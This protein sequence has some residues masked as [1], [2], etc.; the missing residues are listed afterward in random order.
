MLVAVL[1]LLAASCGASPHVRS[2]AQVER[3]L[4]AAGLQ[5]HRAT[6]TMELESVDGTTP[7]TPPIQEIVA[8]PASES[9][10]PPVFTVDHGRAVVY[11]YPTEDAAA[12][13]TAA[14]REHVLVVRNVVA[15]TVRGTLSR[16]L[17]E[18]LGRLA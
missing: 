8:M 18:V 16:H 15:V 17:R 14:P 13:Y 10:P 2:A 6:I 12:P 1:A 5:P 4:R 9:R 11:V 3:A 7:K